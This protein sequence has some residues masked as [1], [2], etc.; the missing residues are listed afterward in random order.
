[1]RRER[2]PGWQ[3]LSRFVRQALAPENGAS[4]ICP[5]MMDALQPVDLLVALKLAASG[6]MDMSLRDIEEQ[7]GVPRSTASLSL[8]RLGSHRIVRDI[9]GKR[10]IQRIALRDLIEGGIRWIAPGE[11]GDF[12][13]GLLTSHAA[14]PL[15]SHLMGDP[16]PLVMPLPHGPARG[17][18]V[19]P[20]HP[21]APQAAAK[22]EQLYRLL[23]IADAFRVGRAR[24]REVAR[25]E[26]RRWV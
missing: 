10:K 18:A 1:M 15:A 13:L 17:R 9:G 7:L 8:K 22:D 24:D 25:R 19:T 6:D 11:V 4:I 3:V 23:V 20:I 21:L 26:L 14:E 5:G 16:E 2:Q 12:E